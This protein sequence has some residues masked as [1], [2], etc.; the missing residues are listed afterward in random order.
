MSDSG[1]HTHWR[2]V[3][4]VA[5]AGLLGG[6]LLA[7][8]D[9]GAGWL[10]LPQFADRAVFAIQ[11]GLLLPPLG[12]LLATVCA[13]PL[14]MMHAWH[15]RALWLCAV[16]AP[17]HAYVAIELFAGGRMSGL[18]G[19]PA[20]Q[21]GAFVLLTASVAASVWVAT[22]F[23]PWARRY[24][25][26]VATACTA[27][28]FAISKLDQHAFANLYEYLHGELT[29]LAGALCILAAAVLI[30]GRVKALADRPAR[31]VTLGLTLGSLIAL[32]VAWKSQQANQ[33][34][35]VAMLAPRAPHAH[36]TLLAARSLLPSQQ[37]RQQGR[38]LDGP[39]RALSDNALVPGGNVLLITVDALRPDHLGTYAYQRPT[40]PVIDQFAEA[41]VVFE[42]AYAQ[43]PHSS[44]SIS[45]L[46]SSHYIHQLVDLELS[47][48]EATLP[49][50]LAENGYHTAAFFTE[51]IFHTEGVRLATYDK[52]AFGFSRFDHTAAPAPKMTELALEEIRRA[53][54]EQREPMFIWVHYFDVHEPYRAT[55]FGTSDMDRYDS[56]IR[57]VDRAIE[58]LVREARAASKRPWVIALTSD[59]GEEFRDHGGL[60][61]GSTLFD[62]QIRVPL[63]IQAPGLEPRRVAQPVEVVDLAPTLLSLV[64]HTIPSTM[65]G[66]DLRSLLT[67]AANDWTTPVFGAVIH[68]RMVVQWPHKLVADLRYGTR[69][70]YNLEAD[71]HEDSNLAD[72]QSETVERLMPSI[73]GWLDG[74]QGADGA[75]DITAHQA[76]LNLGRLGDR[77]AVEPLCALLSDSTANQAERLEAAQLLT[78]LSDHNSKQALLD[79]MRGDDAQ[80]AAEAAVALGRMFDPRAQDALRGLMTTS[81]PMLR[82]RAAVSLA[83]LRDPAAVPGLVDALYTHPSRYERDEAIRWL[84][85]LE[86][87]VALEPL[88]SILGD[89][90]ARH[91]VLYALGHL[92][93]RRA[94]PALVETLQREQNAFRKNRAVRALGQLGAPEAI[95]ALLPYLGEGLELTNMSESLVRL[96]AID[97]GVLGGIDIG[98][99]TRRQLRP[100]PKPADCNARAEKHDWD[101]RNRTSCVLRKA[102]T[103]TLR[104][105]KQRDGQQIRLRAQSSET[106]SARLTVSLGNETH[107]IELTHTWSEHALSLPDGVNLVRLSADAAF[108]LDHVLVLPAID[109]K[110][111]EVN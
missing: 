7:G 71:P 97:R 25:W 19:K 100:T 80:V 77:R 48:P 22:R 11:L 69:E 99:R 37:K 56:E 43:A 26:F 74:L 95:D 104:P 20:W 58:T 51:G 108:G 46:M 79:A 90:Q 65:R 62:E 55:D 33:N 63:I 49:R 17:W 2:M 85:R 64:G 28:A 23:W 30:E 5:L 110:T 4:H 59:H 44:Y 92:G 68:K 70:L 15:K 10:F 82:A 101:Y 87:P 109:R 8:L 83:R 91:L 42:R 53:Q 16:S 27:L 18:S 78:Q 98:P 3:S 31:W 1:L 54:K 94:L 35:Y 103:I 84:G 13:A 40:S 106:P 29:L 61:H 12:C 96:G 32:S 50:A 89:S 102:T 73:Y 72:S 38:Q 88:L 60:Y 41:S 75:A 76:A 52:S 67:G 111:E 66:D 107:N 57:Q 14:T 47:L 24:R 6:A 93:D 39:A 34:V 21:L 105:P 81:D 86:D 45:S 9:F 36:S